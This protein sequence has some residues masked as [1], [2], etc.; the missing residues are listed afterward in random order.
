V[1]AP[2][3]GT[4]TRLG[5]AAG[6]SVDTGA[7]VAEVIDLNRLAV[8]TKV[9]EAQANALA[10]GEDMLIS[11]TTPVTA[12]LSVISPAIDSN[13]GTVS[14][15]ALLPS[16]SGLS[17]GQFVQ[18]KIVTGTHTNCLAAPENS[19]VTDDS[20]QSAISLIKDNEAHQIPVQAGYRENGWVEVEGAGIGEGDQSPNR[21]SLR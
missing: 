21:Q 13:D 4:V 1:V 6:Q 7:A 3:A 16:G 11:N 12:S 19:V 10:A 20:G 15:W 9:P 14:A 2:V 17:P 18:L 5:V 8:E